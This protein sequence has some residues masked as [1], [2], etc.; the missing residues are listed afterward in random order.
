[1]ALEL[2][3]LG[4]EAEELM[5]TR[6]Q[7]ALVRAEALVPGAGREAIEPLL[8]DAALFIDTAAWELPMSFDRVHLSEEGHRLMAER[9]QTALTECL[10]D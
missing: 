1:M 5:G 3:K 4:F 7:Q 2:T 8:A 10:R 6:V 9:L